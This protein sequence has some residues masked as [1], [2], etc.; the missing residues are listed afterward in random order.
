VT[1]PY[2]PLPRRGGLQHLLSEPG[3]TLVFLSRARS[4][5]VAAFMSVLREHDTRMR[6]VAWGVTGDQAL[7]DEALRS[8]FGTAFRSLAMLRDD[9]VFASW[10]GE[11]CRTVA[12]D[13]VM[14]RGLSGPLDVPVD[15]APEPPAHGPGFWESVEAGLLSSVPHA[16][17]P[18][19]SVRPDL[20]VVLDIR[21][22]SGAGPATDQVPTVPAP[23]Q[24]FGPPDR[25]FGPP[26]RSPMVYGPPDGGVPV[27]SPPQALLR[28]DG[29][30]GFPAPA[31]V[32]HDE[33]PPAA[34]RRTWPWVAGGG[35]LVAIIGV[36]ALVSLVRGL[37]GTPGVEASSPATTDQSSSAAPSQAAQPPSTT[38]PPP[39]VAVSALATRPA[40]ELPA[41]VREAAPGAPQGSW[42]EWTD[43]NGT[44]ALVLSVVRAP[45]DGVD[46][47]GAPLTEDASTLY[48][49]LLADKGSGYRTLRQLTDPGPDPCGFD[50]AN[51][52]TPQSVR[53][54][55]TDADGTGEVT[56]GWAYSCTS[57][58]SPSTVKLALLEGGDKYIL[59]GTGW[60]VPPPGVAELP[61]LPDPP[62]TPDPSASSWPAGAYDVAVDLYR[63]LYT[64][65]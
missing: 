49:T 14:V 31:P 35:A 63:S 64:D 52:F 37:G 3:S 33:P 16:G 4:G 51:D 21:S 47:G 6:A 12:T 45:R 40:G 59:R 17:P 2:S 48:A 50:L 42:F 29:V 15:A 28:P 36:V 61:P 13:L 54:T 30:G 41:A 39:A 53:L 26:D 62:F 1:Q 7:M 34:P 46:D 8:A 60:P 27:A 44:N 24:Y 43:A 25:S 55:D 20:D 32:W 23:D 11:I 56:V 65:V 57:E 38:T 5:D 19:P 9:G 18:Q 22:G 58:V 10:L